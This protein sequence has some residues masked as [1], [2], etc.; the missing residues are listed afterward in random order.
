[1]KYRLIL[2]VSI[3]FLIFAFGCKKKD[4]EKSDVK[5]DAA[6]I[7]QAADTKDADDAKVDDAK[8][9][10][11]PSVVAKAA[12]QLAETQDVMIMGDIFD[13]DINVSNSLLSYIPD[14]SLMLY[15]STQAISADDPR[16]SRLMR[17]YRKLFES[18]NENDVLAIYESLGEDLTGIN[19]KDGMKYI[20]DELFPLLK[21]YKPE[22]LEAFGYDPTAKVDSIAYFN[23][24]ELVFK[25]NGIK[26]ATKMLNWL[27]MLVEKFDLK[28]TDEDVNGKAWK[29][30]DL[31]QVG[32]LG[33]H[34]EG[35]VSTVVVCITPP[36]RLLMPLPYLPPKLP[37]ASKNLKNTP[38]RAVLLVLGLS[39][40][41][42]SQITS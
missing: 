37:T 28:S 36:K 11:P 41:S 1:M 23:G 14:N 12:P 9:D 24:T 4:E 25:Q 10:A 13:D 17:S 31:A 22:A 6:A 27:S 40:T 20:I 16:L 2:V 32:V 5:V 34:V 15:A 21:D 33:I 30:F 35:N 29:T 7:E 3:L 18:I 19:L 8:A 26:D 42:S 39:I 38:L